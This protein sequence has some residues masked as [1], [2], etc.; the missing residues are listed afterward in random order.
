MAE[1]EIKGTKKYLKWL[2][3]HLAKEHPRTRGKSKL[4]YRF[5]CS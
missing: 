3:G 5:K 4:S 2:K 1:L